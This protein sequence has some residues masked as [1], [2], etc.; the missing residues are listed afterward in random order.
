MAKVANT[1]TNLKDVAQTTE[2]LKA[3][4]SEPKELTPQVKVIHC[5]YLSRNDK[6]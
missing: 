5:D 3:A 4:V 1:V 6:T 2:T